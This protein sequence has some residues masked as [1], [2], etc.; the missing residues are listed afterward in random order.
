MKKPKRER[1]K[2][3]PPPNRA[4]HLPLRPSRRTTSPLSARRADRRRKACTRVR[5]ILR[6]AGEEGTTGELS[7][8]LSAQARTRE[9]CRA[10]ALRET[11][12]RKLPAPPSRPCRQAGPA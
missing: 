9:L 3:K 4:L 10:R 8:R 1:K 7:P 6:R 5:G 2:R 11:K 12:G